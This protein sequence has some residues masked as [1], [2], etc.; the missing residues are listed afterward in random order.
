MNMP[1]LLV[2][3]QIVFQNVDNTAKLQSEY[4]KIPKS[5]CVFFRCPFGYRLV[6]QTPASAAV[7]Q[8]VNECLDME[9]PCN[10]GRCI[11]AG[12]GFVCECSSE[13]GGP[14]CSE[15]R[16]EQTAAA[17]IK[18]GALLVIVACVVLLLC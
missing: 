14:T 11:D 5:L 3:Q 18:T 6:S 16:A 10:G 9:N 17:Y 15:R 1:A 12:S 4:D 8:P 13:R 7:C 2:Q